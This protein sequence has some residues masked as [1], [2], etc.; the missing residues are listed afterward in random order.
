MIYGYAR[1]SRQDQELDRQ[2]LEL[3]KYDCDR[4]FT[5]K[6]SGSKFTRD[7]LD[8]M[9]SILTTGDTVV[10]TQLD[11]LGRSL[12]ELLILIEQ[13]EKDGI[14]FISITQGLNTSTPAGKLIFSVLGAVAEFERNLIIERT[15]QGLAVARS[16]GI[17]LGRRYKLNDTQ[18]KTAITL[19]QSGTSPKEICSLL[20]I[21]KATYYNV[22]YPSVKDNCPIS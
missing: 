15:N 11:R 22:I 6:I 17:K 7:G 4:I 20:N 9:L 14:N 1:V 19:A 13:W 2:L 10:V 16:K 18:M 12:R 21:S 5:D 3:S 8:E